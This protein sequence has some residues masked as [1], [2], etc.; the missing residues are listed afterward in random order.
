MAPNPHV[1]SPFITIYITFLFQQQE[2]KRLDEKEGGG[3]GGVSNSAGI[4]A[5]EV[6]ESE[7]ARNAVLHALHSQVELAKAKTELKEA[8]L[9]EQQRQNQQQ[10]QQPELQPPSEQRDIH[11]LMR[12]MRDIAEHEEV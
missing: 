3:G 9:V 5:L 8:G 2:L 7:E 11:D 12:L 1:R 4:A 6:A 10:Q